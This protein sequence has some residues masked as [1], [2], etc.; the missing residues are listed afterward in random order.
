MDARHLIRFFDIHQRIFTQHAEGIAHSESCS[1]PP[2]GGN[3]LNWVLGHIVASRNDVLEVLGESPIWTETEAAPYARGSAG[4]LGPADARPLPEIL[5]ALERSHAV[6][7]ARLEPMT[8]VEFERP[9]G[10]ETVGSRLAFLQFH[11][12]YH[13]GQVGLLRRM[14]GREGVIR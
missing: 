4:T 5:A 1:A 12:S 7:R 14:L 6:I 11:E 13:A 8:A 3:S 9:S 10:K 2:G